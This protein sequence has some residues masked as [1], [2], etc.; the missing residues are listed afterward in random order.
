MQKADT[1]KQPGEDERVVAKSKLIRNLVSKTMNWFPT[2]LSSSTSH[3]Q[4]VLA[5]KSSSLDLAGMVKPVARDSKDNAASSSQVRQSDAS[6]GTTKN[7]V[8]TRLSRH[9]HFGKHAPML[10]S[11][12]ILYQPTV[13]R[14]WVP[15]KTEKKVSKDSVIAA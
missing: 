8:S 1:G 5:A 10:S 4:G 11:L 12:T 7:F 2:A 14:K 15:T 13:L 9:N 3:S 6:S